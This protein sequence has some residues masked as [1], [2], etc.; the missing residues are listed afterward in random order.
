MTVEIF[1]PSAYAAA[2]RRD[3]AQNKPSPRRE[4]AVTAFAAHAFAP[5]PQALKHRAPAR[6]ARRKAQHR[7]SR[8]QDRQ[9]KQKPC[10]LVRDRRWAST[11]GKLAQVT[12]WRGIAQPHRHHARHQ[13]QGDGKED[14]RRQQIEIGKDRL[15]AELVRRHALHQI[16]VDIAQRRKHPGAIAPAVGQRS[17]RQRR[18]AAAEKR[19]QRGNARARHHRQPGKQ[20]QVPCRPV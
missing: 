5:T 16:D 4:M 18:K 14:L 3:R 6:Q 15:A 12:A 17:D 9:R 10:F 8:G 20:A 11:N 13:H 19:R 2:R 7:K 1:A